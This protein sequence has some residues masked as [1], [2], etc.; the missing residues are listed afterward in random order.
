MLIRPA[1][2]E[3]AAGIGRVHVRAWRSTYVGMVPQSL[4]DGLD[5]A[6]SAL[7]WAERLQAPGL[8]CLVAERAGEVVG[9][10]F[11]GPAREGFPPEVDGELHALYLLA[12]HQGQGLGRALTEAFLAKLRAQ[13]LGQVGVWVIAENPAL[14]FYEALGARPVGEKVVDMGGALV[15]ELALAWRLP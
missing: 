12:E 9:F 1:S 11:G 4:L 3:D 2:P 15:K 14:G 13:G 6:R 10:A 5:E 7:R 8:C